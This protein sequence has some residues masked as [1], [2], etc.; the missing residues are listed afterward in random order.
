MINFGR[1]KLHDEK[2]R[3]HEHKARKGARIASVR[4]I[5]AA[6]HVDQFFLSG[7]VG[8][9]ATNMLNTRMAFRSRKRFNTALKGIKA[10]RYLNNEDG[11]R[12]YSEATKRDPFEGAY[13]PVDEGSSAIGVMKWLKSQGVISAYDWTFTFAAFLDALQRQPVLVGT[14]WYDDMMETDA[15][16]IVHSTATGDSGGHEYLAN[17]IIRPKKLIGFE[18]SWGEHPEGFHATFF[19]PFDLAEELIIRQEG[20]VA[21]PK[22]L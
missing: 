5:L 3:E 12:N 20:D 16:G 10:N 14:N 1:I 11:I 6:D 22:F 17:A 4:H 13:P 8:F 15:N 21:V 9:S 7:C 2:S 18:Q 19:M